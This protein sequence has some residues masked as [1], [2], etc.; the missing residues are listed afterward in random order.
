MQPSSLKSMYQSQA[1]STQGEYDRGY[2]YV[3]NTDKQGTEWAMHGGTCPGY[4]NFMRMD[5]TNKTG[6]AV[7]ANANRFNTPSVINGLIEVLQ[8]A[9]SIERNTDQHDL[10]QYTGFYDVNP[11]NSEYYVASWG[12]DLMFLYLPAHSALTV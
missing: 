8:R 3:V 4:V 12:N 10:S 1:Q 6:Y 11:W 5:I 7:L 9:E 2:A